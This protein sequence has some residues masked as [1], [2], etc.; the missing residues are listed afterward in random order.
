MGKELKKK[1]G[2]RITAEQLLA[3]LNKFLIIGPNVK[4]AIFETLGLKYQIS[5]DKRISISTLDR[6]IIKYDTESSDTE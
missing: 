4:Q 1:E 5:K 3:A 6:G 2:V